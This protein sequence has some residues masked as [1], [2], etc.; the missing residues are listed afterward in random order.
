[1]RAILRAAE[2]LDVRYRVGLQVV[3]ATGMRRGEACGLR[4][5]DIDVDRRTL[6][7]DEAVIP[8][9]GGAA[10]KS[11]KTRAGIRRVTVDSGTIA[12]LAELRAAQWELAD[13]CGVSILDN[14]FVLSMEPG[15][16]VPLHPD[17]LSH[18]FAKARELAG[19][20]TELHLH[21]LRHFQATALDAV[22]SE[23]RRQKQSRLGWSTVHMARHYTD[24][25]DE[26]DRRAAEHLGRLLGESG[27][28]QA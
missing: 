14:G 2:D 26:E 15:G 28:P 10:V 22:I 17:S 12:A 4:W 9:E 5:S 19:V 8:A 6:M 1:V 16:A 11:P 24:A 25:V 20:A 7:I 13:V 23:R 18:A 27:D 3:A 21:S